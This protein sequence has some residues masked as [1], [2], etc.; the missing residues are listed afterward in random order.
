MSLRIRIVITKTQVE[1]LLGAACFYLFEDDLSTAVGRSALRAG[2]WRVDLLGNGGASLQFRVGSF[3]VSVVDL[4][5]VT[6][7]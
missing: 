7:A 4:F 2:C 3:V 5:L 1:T 6:D